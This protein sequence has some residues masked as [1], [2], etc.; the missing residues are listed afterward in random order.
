[1]TLPWSVD[2]SHIP[3]DIPFTLRGYKGE[4]KDVPI[5]LQE[6]EKE[7]CRLTNQPFP[8]LEMVFVRSWT[9]FKVSHRVPILMLDI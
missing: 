6:L 4:A 2:M 1:M 8:I 7:Y 3:K 9:L 5:A